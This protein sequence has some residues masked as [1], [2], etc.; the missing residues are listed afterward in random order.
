MSLGL[1]QASW[2]RYNGP[3]TLDISECTNPAVKRVVLVL[4]GLAVTQFNLFMLGPY[5]GDDLTGSQ[6]FA[7]AAA[8]ANSGAPLPVRLGPPMRS[9]PIA[10][11]PEPSSRLLGF[12]ALQRW[13]CWAGWRGVAGPDPG[14]PFGTAGSRRSRQSASRV[15]G[16]ERRIPRCR[17]R[18]RPRSLASCGEPVDDP[19]PEI[20]E[21][22]PLKSS[23]CRPDLLSVVAKTWLTMRIL[24][25]K[26]RSE[27]MRFC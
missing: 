26:E 18:R 9:F 12:S 19:N 1:F 17:S 25:A 8:T 14:R 16:P 22:S 24:S 10:L 15:A 6:G 2:H 13:R 5:T 23:R 3:T 4:T 7:A 11:V 21:E 27:A 20:G